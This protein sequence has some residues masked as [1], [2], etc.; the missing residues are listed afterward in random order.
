MSTA[1][2]VAR[3]QAAATDHPLAV[4]G[5]LT[6][7]ERTPEKPYTYAYAPPEGTAATNVR[8]R[9]E[10]VEITNARPFA[11]RLKLD[12]EGFQVVGHRTAVRDYWDALQS[13]E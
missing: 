2:A 3:P 9:A 7:I 4:T 11:D 12:V 6:F 5:S 10:P 1:A 13:S 8:T